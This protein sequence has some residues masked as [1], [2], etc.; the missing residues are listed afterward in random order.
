MMML[1]CS[2]ANNFFFKVFAINNKANNFS[3][4]KIVLCF[5]VVVVVGGGGNFFFFLNTFHVCFL[6]KKTDKTEINMT[7]KTYKTKEK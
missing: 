5:F 7:T 3:L 2:L 4:K 1:R 6:P